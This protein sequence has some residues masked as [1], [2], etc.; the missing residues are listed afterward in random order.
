[1]AARNTNET[2]RVI[3]N[4][5]SD[6]GNF[7]RLRSLIS[8]FVVP[9][10][11]GAIHIPEGVTALANRKSNLF[12]DLR[13]RLELD[14][15]RKRKKIALSP[16]NCSKN[17]QPAPSRFNTLNTVRFQPAVVGTSTLE[18]FGSF[19]ASCSSKR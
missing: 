9:I 15:A 18:E 12:Y 3:P 7:K 19:A 2:A 11:R 17:P 16:L 14:A 13:V 6:A 1:M 8:G 4:C 5:D 10:P